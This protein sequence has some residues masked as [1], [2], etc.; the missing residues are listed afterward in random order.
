VPY[1]VPI[2]LRGER[3]SSRMNSSGYTSR[4]S[5]R[6]S[7]KSLCNSSRLSTPSAPRQGLL[8]IEGIHA[9]DRHEKGSAKSL[10]RSGPGQTERGYL[11]VDVLAVEVSPGDCGIEWVLGRTRIPQKSQSPS[12][13]LAGHGFVALRLAGPSKS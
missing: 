12:G 4:S 1:V 6:A 3:P 13:V 11:T 2:R 8:Q 5:P 10:I 9:G 7:A